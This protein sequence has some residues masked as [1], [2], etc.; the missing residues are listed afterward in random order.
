MSESQA[1]KRRWRQRVEWACRME[2]WLRCEPPMWRFGKW[3]RWK[4]ARPKRPDK[5][6]SPG[7]EG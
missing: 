1:H 2:V 3:R 4:A 7:G 6:V 5:I